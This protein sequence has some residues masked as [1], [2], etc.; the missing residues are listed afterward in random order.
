MDRYEYTHARYV[1]VPSPVRDRV[2]DKYGFV[3]P[4]GKVIGKVIYDRVWP[5]E[6]LKGY[7]IVQ[8]NGLTGIVDKSIKF[9][10]PP[11]FFN[12]IEMPNS[13]VVTKVVDKI[14]LR[15]VAEYLFSEL[16]PKKTN[17]NTIKA[18]FRIKHT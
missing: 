12:F 8:L 16:S 6:G 10:V 3:S 2:T 18:I 13:I 9:V 14:G 7:A 15:E 1:E 5:F 4:K 11:I 17:H